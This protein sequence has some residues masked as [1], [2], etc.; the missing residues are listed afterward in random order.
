MP[1][2]FVVSKHGTMKA[3]LNIDKEAAHCRT[4]GALRSGLPGDAVFLGTELFAPFGVG[5]DNLTIRC[6]I[7]VLRQVQDI[8]P[9]EHH[10]YSLGRSRDRVSNLR[11]PSACS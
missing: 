4:E 6:R 3:L 9:F 5:F 2:R 8:W 1:A 7:A 10:P 11:H